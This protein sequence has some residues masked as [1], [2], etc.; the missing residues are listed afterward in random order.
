MKTAD[1]LSAT[2]R[3]NDNLLLSLTGFNIK[4]Q[5]KRITPTSQTV[6]FTTTYESITLKEVEI[7]ARKLWGSRD[8]LNYLVSAYMKGQDRTI[9]DILKQLP[10]ITLEGGMVKYQG[11]PINISTLRTWICLRANIASQR[12][13]L[14]LKMSVRYR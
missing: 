3:T 8:T 12:M 5:V 7:K 6:N 9:G 13:V 14:K 11:V 1:T 2:P 10:G 4:R